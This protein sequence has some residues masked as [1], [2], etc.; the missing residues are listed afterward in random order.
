MTATSLLCP[1]HEKLPSMWCCQSNVKI[2][3]PAPPN[4]LWHI[5]ILLWQ[6]HQNPKGLLKAGKN[7]KIFF[8]SKIVGHIT[9]DNLSMAIHMH[10]HTGSCV[11]VLLYYT[12]CHL[13]HS[14][15]PQPV[16]WSQHRLP[17]RK[18]DAAFWRRK[19]KILK[20]RILKSE[21]ITKR[22]A[23]VYKCKTKCIAVT[24]FCIYVSLF[25]FNL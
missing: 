23:R 3:E 1:R 4:D 18:R 9:K 20:Y 5:L 10:F 22:F 8:K 24:Y 15:R 17:V 14:K 13:S 11:H 16:D 6:G 2:C 19:N 7:P 21:R 25:V 12:Q